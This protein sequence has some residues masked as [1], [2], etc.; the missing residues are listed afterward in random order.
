MDG[1]KFCGN[2]G[3][4][5]ELPEVA[6]VIENEVKEEPA[7]AFATA[8][9]ATVSEIKEEAAP[10]IEVTP[11]VV[12]VQEETKAEAEASAAPEIEPEMSEE[13]KTES[14]AA[15]GPKVEPAATEG[16][17]VEPAPAVATE[18]DVMASI[19]EEYKP[20]GMWGYFGLNI[21]FSIPLI[22]LIFILIF[23]FGGTKNKNLCNFAR[24]FF[25][26]MVISVVLLVALAIFIG[27]K[28]GF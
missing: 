27:V 1:I 5:V 23:S 18:A 22:G 7:E 8:S 17:K 26:W 10:E 21:L 9:D 11:A 15:E 16:P 4:A 14:A 3:A 2:C 25:C 19:P 24:S 6:P 28:L 20:I 13:P 12:P